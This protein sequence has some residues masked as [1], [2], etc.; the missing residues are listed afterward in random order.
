MSGHLVTSEDLNVSKL[1]KSSYFVPDYQR[2]I[3]M[4]WKPCSAIS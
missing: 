4:D 2:G 1:F 3:R